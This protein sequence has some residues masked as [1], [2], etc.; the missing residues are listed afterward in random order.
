[1]QTLCK[2]CKTY[3]GPT[4]IGLKHTISFLCE[5]LDIFMNTNDMCG[6]WEA[7]E[8]YKQE[9]NVLKKGW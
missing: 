7:S 2:D 6:Y 5:R 3:D 8:G 4:D 1:M 9:Q